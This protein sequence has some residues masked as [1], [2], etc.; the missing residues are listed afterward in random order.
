[1]AIPSSLYPGSPPPAYDRQGVLERL[2]GD[3]QLCDEI[4]A[5][6]LEEARGKIADL[7][8]FLREEAWEKARQQ[9]H[10]LEGLAGNVGASALADLFHRIH[11]LVKRGDRPAAKDLAGHL[12]P[13]FTRLRQELAAA[14]FFPGD[15]R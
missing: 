15:P 1:M 9:A 2:E 7:E 5:V 10:A 4:L 8:R 12:G 11:V 3:E 14:H 6:F 13:E